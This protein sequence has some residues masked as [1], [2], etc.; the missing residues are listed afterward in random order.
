MLFGNLVFAKDEMPPSSGVEQPMAKQKGVIFIGIDE[1]SGDKTYILKE[2]N[3]NHANFLGFSKRC[4]KDLCNSNAGVWIDGIYHVCRCEGKGKRYLQIITVF[5]ESWSSIN[6]EVMSLLHQR[7][8]KQGIVVAKAGLELAENK[9]GPNHL[10]VGKSLNNLAQ[11]YYAKKEYE[12]AEP[13]YKRALE[14][15]EAFLGSDHPTVATVL[16]NL[17]CL[18]FAQKNYSKAEKLYKRVLVIWE[19]KLGP[20]H[21]NVAAILENLAALYRVTN[22]K[23]EANKLVQ[24]AV[25]IRKV[26]R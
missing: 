3:D 9:N 7:K 8:Y 14:I 23:E 16:N 13:L 10:A 22:R 15:E 1:Y 21:P 11:L 18:Y 25:E 4:V 6:Q 12:Q 19:K 24:R 20:N 26:A 2:V 17:A 5:K